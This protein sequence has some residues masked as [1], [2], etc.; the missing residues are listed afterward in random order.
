MITN[1]SKERES[2]FYVAVRFARLRDRSIGQ[3]DEIQALFEILN[4]SEQIIQMSNDAI[5]NYA[6]NRKQRSPEYIQQTCLDIIIKVGDGLTKY[7]DSK[8]N[9]ILKLLDYF[10]LS[11]RDVSEE[12]QKLKEFE[13]L[14]DDIKRE[15]DRIKNE[16]L[17]RPMSKYSLDTI[18]EF[19]IFQEIII[20]KGIP[21]MRRLNDLED[22]IQKDI[23]NQIASFTKANT[24]MDSN[25]LY[26]LLTGEP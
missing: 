25:D 20:Q 12:T 11:E 22:K 6:K 18:K 21:L 13:V 14:W 16:F 26:K 23:V 3:T 4:G 9:R 1:P 10:R 17:S 19:K 7:I 2:P 24:I 15:Y 5:I 8:T